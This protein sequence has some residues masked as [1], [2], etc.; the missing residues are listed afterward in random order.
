MEIK[1]FKQKLL[2][3]KPYGYKI[4]LTDKEL[5]TFYYLCINLSRHP[6]ENDLKKVNMNNIGSMASKILRF[7]DDYFK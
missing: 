5:E 1:E 3:T 6:E 2:Y 7:R 4:G